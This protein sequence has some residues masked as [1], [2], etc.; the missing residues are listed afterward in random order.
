M[1]AKINKAYNFFSKH[2]DNNYYRYLN[3]IKRNKDLGDFDIYF[4]HSFNM[5]K[6]FEQDI[7][8]KLYDIQFPLYKKTYV[9][10]PFEYESDLEDKYMNTYYN[11]Q[12]HTTQRKFA[13]EIVEL[14]LHAILSSNGLFT[15]IDSN[16]QIGTTYEILYAI[17]NN[18]EVFIINSTSHPFILC[19]RI[20]EKTFVFKDMD[21]FIDCMKLADEMYKTFNDLMEIKRYMNLSIVLSEIKELL[22]EKYGEVL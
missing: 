1:N 5:N 19:D 15:Y 10:N 17:K 6:E 14:D 16:S 9:Y 8:N 11:I 4:A 21:E 3:R 20:Y 2:I 7:I 18:V 12:D 13:N 22:F